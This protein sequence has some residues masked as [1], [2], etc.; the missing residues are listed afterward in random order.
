M[1][2]SSVS[3][4]SRKMR[5][6]SGAPKP[7]DGK[8]YPVEGGLVEGA[9]KVFLQGLEKNGVV[10]GCVG[11]ERHRGVEFEMVG[12]AEDVINGTVPDIQD[13]LGAFAE[14]WAEERMIE[15]GDGLF[16][17]RNRIV[18]RGFAGTEATNLR[19]DEPHPMGALSAGA[20][21]SAD[22]FKNGI[23]GF[24]KTLEMVSVFHGIHGL[25]QVSRPFK[26]KKA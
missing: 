24:E 18:L 15:I 10:C 20:Q 2:L 11:E 22:L 16:A 7:R 23:L 19:K 4:M 8:L 25:V 6:A 26:L 1:V 13:E 5:G 3:Q 9:G 21:L 17:R 14:T 12:I